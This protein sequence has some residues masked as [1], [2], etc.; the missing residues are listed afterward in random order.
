MIL[1]D[2]LFAF[3]FSCFFCITASVVFY[4]DGTLLQ[5]VLL[6][7]CCTLSGIMHGALSGK[8]R[9]SMLAL[10]PAL[11]PLVTLSRDGD[12]W[13]FLLFPVLFLA[14]IYWKNFKPEHDSFGTFFL[15]GTGISVFL[16]LIGYLFKTGRP[17]IA[18]LYLFAASGTALMRTL[19]LPGSENDIGFQKNNVVSLLAAAAGLSI[20]SAEVI[21][22]TILKILG[23]FYKK[24]I[25][26]IIYA[27]SY[28]GVWVLNLIFKALAWIFKGVH[29]EMELPEIDTTYLDG[30]AVDS[31]EAYE[32][33]DFPYAALLRNIL[34]VILVLVLTAYIVNRIMKMKNK[35]QFDTGKVEIIREPV[36]KKEK[37]SGN[38]NSIRRTYRKYL[39]LM[40][41]SG[42]KRE[43]GTTSEEVLE[44][45][46][47]A[48]I[49]PRNEAEG[50]REIYLRARYDMKH[51]P[52]SKDVQEAKGYM[53][54]LKKNIQ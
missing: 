51:E 20:V 11:I 37:L 31:A 28:V 9:V 44:S 17:M 50:L 47:S 33:M 43:E 2:G 5:Y 8:G 3:T 21:W 53:S 39:D 46:I 12:A 41:N 45:G 49:T 16:I 30:T 48:K 52:E 29:F 24:V 19:R 23:W 36:K 13:V 35:P 7:L 27:F 6:P 14:V 15:A 34:L 25:L 40:K 54:V 18:F 26:Q 22:K 1:I 42:I 38:R 32:F 10:L 4:P